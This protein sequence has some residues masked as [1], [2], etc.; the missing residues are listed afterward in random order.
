VNPIAVTSHAYPYAVQQVNSKL[1]DLTAHTAG[2]YFMGLCTAAA[3]TWGATQQAY[4]FVSDITTAYTEVSSGGYAR[5]D[6]STAV[7][8][9]Q[10]TDSN[11]WT[12]SSPISFGTN[13]TLSAASGFVFT[14]LIGSGDSTYPVLAIIDFG[15]TVAST[16]GAWSFTPDAVNGLIY[17]TET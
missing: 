10:N 1:L 14:K 3:S 6:F 12:A 9:T 4:K 16:S 2:S 13:I 8:L 11:V 5:V 15:G 17:W 7:T